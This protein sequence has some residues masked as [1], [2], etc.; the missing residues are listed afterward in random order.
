MTLA[1]PIAATVGQKSHTTFI[2]WRDHK[3]QRGSLAMFGASAIII[4]LGTDI[5]NCGFSTP[6]LTS[7]TWSKQFF[8]TR[9]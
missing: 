6:E 2:P 9:R 3:S 4:M 5:L 1:D 7:A 8:I